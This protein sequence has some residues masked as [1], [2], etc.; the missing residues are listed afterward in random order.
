MRYADRV[1]LEEERDEYKALA[2]YYMAKCKN[3]RLKTR[4]KLQ[5]AIFLAVLGVLGI[6]GIYLLMSVI[7][8]TIEYLK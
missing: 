1:R 8:S 5:D 3:G 4:E 6:A 7:E 2:E